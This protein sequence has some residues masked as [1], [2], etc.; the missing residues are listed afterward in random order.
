M[1]NGGRH[2]RLRPSL[3]LLRAESR[4]SPAFR[5]VPGV[6]SVATADIHLQLSHGVAA[7][8]VLKVPV[9]T[10][11]LASPGCK[12][13]GPGLGVSEVQSNR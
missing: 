10:G 12:Y 3:S 6:V 7:T 13:P 9:V 4:K 5:T 8:V 1:K 11:G 2:S